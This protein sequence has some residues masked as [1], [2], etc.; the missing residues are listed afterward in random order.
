MLTPVYPMLAERLALRPFAPS[1]FDAL[2]AIQSRDDVTRYLYWGP[3][4]H[5]EVREA[6]V[7]RMR[8]SV[9]A[10]EGQSLSMAI[11]LRDGGALIGTT[12]LDW[13]SA[14]H[15]QGEIGFILH[16]DHQGRGYAGEAAAVLLRLG[17]E[18]LG[19]HRIVGRCDGRNTG[20]ARVMERLGLRQE[21]HLR[22]NEIVKGEWCDELVYAMLASEWKERG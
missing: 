5:D 18:D 17:F 19:L 14:T 3:R 16:P 10:A 2:Y 13:V 11:T 22:E 6:L 4:S 21:A 7:A 9:L 20:S 8:E 1:D 15:R 12:N